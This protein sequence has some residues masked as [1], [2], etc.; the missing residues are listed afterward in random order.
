[1]ELFHQCERLLNQGE[2]IE[3]GRW[4][5]TVL[6]AGQAHQHFFREQFLELWRVTQ[7]RVQVSR[8]A[9]SFAFEDR[10][11]ATEWADG[12][13]SHSYV[14]EPVNPDVSY[15]RLDMLWL[16]WMGEAQSTFERT[17]SQCRAYWNGDSTRDV[18][19]GAQPRWERLIPCGLRVVTR[20]R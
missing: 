15:A 16:T 3:P 19:Q 14:V 7:T 8:L 12:D 5:S 10:D 17:R 9:C 2:I 20:V 18:A 6:A 13:S 4:G 1:M 11:A